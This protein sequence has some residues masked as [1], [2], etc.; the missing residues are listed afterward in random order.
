MCGN[1]KKGAVDIIAAAGETTM[2][3][4]NRRCIIF[5]AALTAV[6]LA[7]PAAAQ[8]AVR[9]GT[10]SIG[11]SLYVIAVAV[12]KLV[13]SHAGINVSVEPLG[14][15]TAN[16]FGLDAGKVDFAIVNVGAAYDGYN[17]VKP[18]TR[19]ADVRLVLQGQPTLRWFLVRAGS[20]IQKPQDLVGKTISSKRRPLPEL[21]QITTAVIKYYKLPADKIRQVSSVNLGEVNRTFRAGSI[22]AAAMPFALRQPVATKLFADGIV[23]PLIITEAD[24]DKIK[25]S[26]PDKFI[27]FQVKANNFQNQPKPFW[28]LAMTSVMATSA[29]VPDDTVY[30]VAKAVLANNKE[31]VRYHASA[32]EWNVENSMKEPKVP[33]HPGAIRYYK[34]IGAWTPDMEK[35]QAALLNK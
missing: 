8:Q 17:V 28:A 27:K 6:L 15:S 3:E 1:A 2:Q 7:T 34:E 20:G 18:F 16:I 13:Q 21:E 4:Y 11:S 31:F 30:K 32:R 5:I 9:L 23:A 22:D 10:S 12:S 25:A 29:K 14:G 19:K 24:F 33:F 26:L 35:A